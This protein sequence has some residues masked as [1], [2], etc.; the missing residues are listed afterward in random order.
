MP[1]A[2][3]TMI[4]NVHCLLNQPNIRILGRKM[5]LYQFALINS[6]DHLL[7]TL[8]CSLSWKLEKGAAWMRKKCLK[9]KVVG[10]I[11][12]SQVCAWGFVE[13]T[14][15]IFIAKGAVWNYRIVT[16]HSSN[17]FDY[18]LFDIYIFFTRKSIYCISD[19]VF[20]IRPLFLCG[21]G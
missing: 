14:R 21:C 8:M 2:L 18:C 15:N 16:F 7:I 1:E 13:Q 19:L 3:V 12:I 9:S 17:L 6:W 11:Q 20:V 4:I 5:S 10:S